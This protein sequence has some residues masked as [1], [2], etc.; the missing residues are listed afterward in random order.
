MII[1]III[2][3]QSRPPLATVAAAMQGSKAFSK[4]EGPPRLTTFAGSP[5]E[6]LIRFS[7]LISRQTAQSPGNRDIPYPRKIMK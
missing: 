6:K 2:D 5:A 4:F 1:I 7:P 3:A